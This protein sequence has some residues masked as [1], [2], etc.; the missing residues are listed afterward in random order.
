[1][2]VGWY[3]DCA[4]IPFTTDADMAMFQHEFDDSIEKKFLGNKIAFLAVRHGMPEIGLELRLQD[5]NTHVAYDLFCMY[6]HNSTSQWSPYHVENKLYKSWYP[7]FNARQLC[8]AELLGSKFIIPC[9]PL[10]MLISEYGN[11]EDWMIPKETDYH[12]S[13]INWKEYRRWTDEEYANAV[14]YY[15]SNG[16]VDMQRTL[17]KINSKVKHKINK[18]PIDDRR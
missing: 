13:N 10:R 14:R 5:T 8:S 2:L 17:K 9:D 15:F 1:M 12:W 18:L 16:T 3:R 7:S 11:E 6:A 4:I